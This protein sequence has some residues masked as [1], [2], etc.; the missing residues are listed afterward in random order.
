MA[1]KKKANW[2][3]QLPLLLMTVPGMLYLF[4]N[5]YIPI[6][7]LFIAFKDIDY[8]KGIFKSDWNG[9]ENFKYLFR[10]EDAFIITRNTILYNLTF[11]IL[12]VVICVAV[13]VMLSE[14]SKK[15]MMKFYQTAL[16]LPHLISIIII[17]YIAYAFLNSDTG[18]INHSIQ[19]AMGRD[20]V[21]FYADPKYWPFILVIVQVWKTMGYTSIIYFSAILGIDRSLYEAAVVDGA[22]K[23][24]QIFY[25][26]LPLL[27]PT[28]ITMV[29]MNV[30]RIFYSDFGLFLQVP[31]N[32]GALFNV[33]N[34]ID[35]YVYRA[36]LLNNDIGMASAAGLYQSI[37]GFLLVLGANLLVRKMDPENALF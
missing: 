16:L 34:T 10:T 20:P 37:V 6:C 1:N 22:G 17:A 36:L 33:T 11:I 7:G 4:I 28:I 30:G 29:L 14:V 26:T 27:R 32:Q 2:K 21:N 24:K 25:I 31:M 18:F 5:N 19:E 23:M 8:S 13:A 12:N 35:T 15:F 9:F 3:A